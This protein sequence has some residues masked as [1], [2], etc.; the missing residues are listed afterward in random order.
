LCKALA[1]IS[2][3]SAK[4]SMHVQAGT[5]A[6][7]G[8][9]HRLSNFSYGPAA[10]TTSY[11]NPKKNG[12][13]LML[14]K[15]HRKSPLGVSNERIKT[16]RK[17]FNLL[18]KF[19]FV[20]LA[21]FPV[22][23]YVTNF[24]GGLSKDSSRWGEFGSYLSGVYGSL[25][26]AVLIY[27]TISSQNQFKRLNEDNIFYRL[28]DALHARILHNSISIDAGEIS[29][30]RSIKYI[31]ELYNRELSQE[32]VKI[33]RN[34]F[35]RSPESIDN[36]HFAKLFQL[37][38]PSDWHAN[39]ESHRNNFIKQILDK[40][41]DD[42]WEL[43]KYYFGSSG[44][45]TDPIKEVLQATG[46]V[47]FYKISF[48]DRQHHYSA[49]L[50]RIMDGYGQLLDGYLETLLHIADVA[51]ASS[52]RLEY[53]RYL[54]SQLTS[55]EIVIIFYM[56]LGSDATRRQRSRTLYD[57]GILS[58]LQTNECLS[59]MIDWPDAEVIDRE[60]AALFPS[61]T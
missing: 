39:F 2:G 56:L 18:A 14:G 3:L 49:V 8:I 29:G 47:N 48:Q 15:K 9:Y 20:A 11:A 57:L 55:Y 26:L 5:K 28:L 23:L 12:S 37:L 21:I 19:G 53:A 42:R 27:T 41:L 30:Y 13:H 10:T 51:K 58:R 4:L 25:A 35:Y 40:N 52:S 46:S 50:E 6:V 22:L 61:Q 45:E 44:F 1:A 24:S 17:V 31:A 7:I 32:A 54:R 34:L 33:A 16:E 36:V 43:L 60:L 59:L 38:Y